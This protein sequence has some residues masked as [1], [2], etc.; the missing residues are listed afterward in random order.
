M[1]LVPREKGKQ[2]LTPPGNDF[3]L[4]K[5]SSFNSNQISLKTGQL[6]IVLYISVGVLYFLKIPETSIKNVR[7]TPK[8]MAR[9]MYH[10]CNFKSTENSRI[11]PSFE[12]KKCLHQSILEFPHEEWCPRQ[13]STF[14]REF[15]SYF[16]GLFFT[17]HQIL[18]LSF[19]CSYSYG[20]SIR[21][22][23]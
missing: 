1:Y 6:C 2:F 23:Y 11:K 3:D 18:R 13:F 22:G 8:V 21:Y 10:N 16:Q 15:L 5:F 4:T 19:V 7:I 12:G 17:S 20:P 14:K 9:F